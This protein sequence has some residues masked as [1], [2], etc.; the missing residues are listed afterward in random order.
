MT[1]GNRVNNPIERILVIQT[2]FIGDAILT[3]PMIQTL[4]SNYPYAAI[5]VVVVPRTAEIFSQHP[6][7]SKIVLFDKRKKD[8]GVAGFFRIRKILIEKR[9]DVIV[10]PHRSLRSALLARTLRPQMSIGFD[11][12]AGRWLFTATVQYDASA[13]EIDRNMSLLRPLSLAINSRE[14]P[15]LYPS[16]EDVRTVDTFLKNAGIR[17]PERIISVA[18]GTIWNT[19]RWPADRFAEICSRLSSSGATIVLLG[20]GEDRSLCEEIVSMSKSER[21]MNLAG[22]FSLLQSAEIIRRSRLLVSN[23]SAPMHLAVAMK[24][25]VVAIFGATVPEF[26]FAPRGPYDIVVETLGLR[27]RPC[28]IHGGKFCPIKTFECMLK[29]HP[30][31]VMEKI[32]FIE[33]KISA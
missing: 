19:K 18:P 29:I 33:Q 3:L 17:N 15:K 20:S 2:A 6:A 11:R 24:T 14:L 26:G 7:I 10:V 31:L 25:P 8:K 27:C 23:D 9:Y 28:A 30:D 1:L 22:K 32:Q 12:S 13:H 16:E 5:D 21:V 4:K